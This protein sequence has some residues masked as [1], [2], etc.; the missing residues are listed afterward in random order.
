MQKSQLVINTILIKRKKEW[1]VILEEQ[2]IFELEP[3]WDNI[4]KEI[5]ADI[6]MKSHDIVRKN[7]LIITNLG[8]LYSDFAEACYTGHSSRIEQCIGY[9]VVIFQAIKFIKYVY[10]MMYMVAYFKKL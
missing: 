2:N 9:F 7:S 5:D 10:E 4:R 3:N 1:I 8:L 6:K